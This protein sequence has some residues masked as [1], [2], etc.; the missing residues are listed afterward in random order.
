MFLRV[1]AALAALG[2]ASACNTLTPATASESHCSRVLKAL[3]GNARYSQEEVQERER[4]DG[5]ERLRAVTVIYVEGGDT[6][7]LMTCLYPPGEPNRAV[8]I[9]YRG[10]R[11]SPQR[12]AEVNAAVARR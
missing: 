12:V 5:A 7:R 10:E 9:S 1:A 11:L 8:G 2:L 3:I 6:R 4:I